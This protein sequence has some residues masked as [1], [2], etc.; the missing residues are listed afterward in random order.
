M[1]EPT[2]VLISRSKEIPVRLAHGP[3][4]LLVFTESEWQKR[5]QPAF[6]VRPK[7]GFFCKDILVTGYRLAPIQTEQSTVAPEVTPAV[8]SRPSA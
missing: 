7:L 8:V 2:H 1:F 3:K 4:G 6:E 5:C